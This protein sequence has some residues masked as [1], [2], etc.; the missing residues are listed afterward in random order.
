MNKFDTWFKAQFGELPNSRKRIE[1]DCKILEMR[2]TA[3]FLAQKIERMKR[4]EIL[5]E[6]AKKAYYGFEAHQTS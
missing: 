1:I 3:N 2:T 6:G 5:Y 4:L